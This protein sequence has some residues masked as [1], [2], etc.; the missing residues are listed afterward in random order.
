MDAEKRHFLQDDLGIRRKRVQDYLLSKADGY[1]GFLSVPHLRD[2]AT[3]YIKFGGKGLRA[4]VLLLSCLER[5]PPSYYKELL[6]LW[7]E[8]MVHREF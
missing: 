5:F 8:S 3:S 2:A 4:Q 6:S 7:A 1:A